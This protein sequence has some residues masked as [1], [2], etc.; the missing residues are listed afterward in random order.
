MRDLNQL[1]SEYMVENLLRERRAQ[2]RIAEATSGQAAAWQRLVSA[3]RSFR[4]SRP[5]PIR[6]PAAL[7]Q[8]ERGTAG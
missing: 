2:A 7:A 8:T 1:Y 3:I 4:A 6:E 5:E